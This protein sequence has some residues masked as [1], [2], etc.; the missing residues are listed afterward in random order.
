[1]GIIFLLLAL[2]LLS[3]VFFR[4]ATFLARYHRTIRKLRRGLQGEK[5]TE[6]TK[7]HSA[8]YFVLPV[9]IVGFAINAAAAAVGVLY[10]LFRTLFLS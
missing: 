6:Y 7:W 1:M 2:L 9:V 3:F 10:V 4:A 5:S 8:L